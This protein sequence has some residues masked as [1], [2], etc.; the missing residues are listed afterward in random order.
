VVTFSSKTP[1]GHDAGFLIDNDAD[2]T[3]EQASKCIRDWSDSALRLWEETPKSVTRKLKLVEDEAVTNALTSRQ[4]A[5]EER[6]RLKLEAEEKARQEA[7]EAERE[8]IG[9]E[10]RLRLTRA[11]LVAFYRER[12]PGK[13]TNIDKIMETYKGRYDVLDAKLKQ[14]YGVGFN[15]ALKPKP[16]SK[17]NNGILSTM[18]T[19]FG[20]RTFGKRKEDEEL[21][22]DKL[23]QE[24]VVV[25]VAASE[26]L[27][28][29]CWSKEGNQIKF[30]KLKKSSKLESEVNQVL[31]L[32]FY[33]VDCR[34][35]SS[36]QEQGRIP[37]SVSMTAD[38]LAGKETT[39]AQE[40][41]F[42]SLRGAVHICV[43]GEGYAALPRIYGHKI[44]KGLAEFIKADEARIQNCAL[45]FLSRGFPFVS[46]LD[47]G[48]AAAHAYLCRDGPKVHL[49]AKN[50]LTDYDPEGSIFAQFER[51]NTSTGM[52]K[53]QRSLQHI[54][55]SGMTVLTKSTMRFET[56]SSEVG[57]E[58]VDDSFQ[59]KGEPKHSVRR[60][61]GGSR[62]ELEEKEPV[63][64]TETPQPSQPSI[65]F[66]NPF[67]RKGAE[68]NA[69][70]NV[71]T[72]SVHSESNEMDVD[73]LSLAYKTS[74]QL[75]EG[76]GD[77][78]PEGNSPASPMRQLSTPQ[79]ESNASQKA[80][81]FA[82]FGASLNN[83][84]KAANKQQP[85]RNPFARFGGLGSSAG[86]T[87]S[88][89]SKGPAMVNHFAGLNQFRKNTM[90]MMK[91]MENKVDSK[92]KAPELA[93]REPSH[94]AI[95]QG[96]KSSPG[97]QTFD[98]SVEVPETT[99]AELPTTASAQHIS[100]KT[101]HDAADEQDMPQAPTIAKV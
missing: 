19:G 25:E 97:S 67:A 93:I 61:F 46:V 48:F 77:P 45:F 29:I 82:G 14:K 8:R 12:N 95:S 50:V 74:E 53:A 71:S 4:E 7:I 1:T 75:T 36:A 86:A 35:E 32:K 69:S 30:Q 89:E 73:S 101:A 83:S 51:A 24:S 15:P 20:T 76:S 98:N 21:T 59:Q 57:N 9:D 3:T 68:K 81:G 87:K 96:M 72:S 88:T 26:V 79:E 6:I 34:P 84:M 5:K 44:T 18:N 99:V 60:F 22:L 54:F 27:P 38:Q 70:R 92:N 63:P 47:G 58:N 91:N 94:T 13:E 17:T 56:L 40:E 37:T 23:K 43:M 66:R 33:L 49:H 85:A 39:K 62:E 28:V 52:E 55:D 41:I 10:A 64:R 80:G 11:R 78:Q 100:E 90:A 2:L 65:P 31:P 16:I 42:E